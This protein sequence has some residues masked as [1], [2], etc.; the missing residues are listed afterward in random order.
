MTFKTKD[1]I[2]K[3]FANC[4]ELLDQNPIPTP[5]YIILLFVEALIK[6]V[7]GATYL[8]WPD[9]DIIFSFLNNSN[10]LSNMIYGV[11][12]ILALIILIV[13]V[14]M[15]MNSDFGF[16]MLRSF[17]NK[18]VIVSAISLQTFL[19]APFLTVILATIKLGVQ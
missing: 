1:L 2:Q 6:A 11:F 7:Y 12:I 14:I 19:M 17:F 5:V 15:T 8:Y 16:F 4:I 9:H 18:V 13:L 3:L 10:F